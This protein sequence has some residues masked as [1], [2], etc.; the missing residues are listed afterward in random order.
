MSDYTPDTGR[1][2]DRDGEADFF[3]PGA[4][5]ENLTEEERNFAFDDNYLEDNPAPPP[6][7]PEGLFP[8][9]DSGAV[10]EGD[11]IV[12]PVPEEASPGG[13]DDVP[14]GDGSFSSGEADALFAERDPFAAHPSGAGAA[15]REEDPFA[16]WLSGGDTPPEQPPGDPFAARDPFA[17][18]ASDAL[19]GEETADRSG[20]VDALASAFRSRQRAEQ[21][22]K[23][24]RERQMNAL[25]DV[26]QRQAA[27]KTPGA[28]DTPG[29][30][31]AAGEGT[32]GGAAKAKAPVST[33]IE[34][35]PSSGGA[36]NRPVPAGGASPAIRKKRAAAR[37]RGKVRRVPEPVTIGRTL[38]GDQMLVYDSELD[39]LD[40]TDDEDLP[41]LRDHMPIRFKR[42]GRTGIAGGLMYAA[43]VIGI[44]VILAGFAWLCASDVL[45]L[46]KEPRAAIV[47]VDEYVPE[48]DD[49]TTVTI[50]DKEV[51]IKVDIDQVAD[52][53]QQ[54]GI[55]EYQWLFKL[56]SRFSH[57]ETRIDPGTYDVS[58][59]LDYRALVT[60]LH[61]GSG[62]QTITRVTF[63]E[64]YSMEQIFTLLE[65]K[66]ICHKNELY[67]AAANYDFDYDFL[68]SST[69]GDSGRLEGFLFPDTYDFYEGEDANIAI[70]RFLRNMD[71]KLSDEIRSAAARRGLSIREL[72]TIAS[73][74]EKE[75]GSDDERPLMASVIYNRL[76]VGMPLQLD[77]T[78]NYIKGTSTLALTTADTEIDDPYNTYL[79]TGLTPGPICNPGLASLQAAAEP[80]S[81]DYWYWY[82]VDGVSTFFTNYNEFKAYADAHPVQS[83]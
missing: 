50:D 17:S 55:I 22:A 20:Q 57:A 29:K 42:Y 58:T 69:L 72:V 32:G 79:Y 68:D 81:T 67:E 11:P 27:S 2:P 52:A 39:E 10:G 14:A 70:N 46:N 53:L 15:A 64:G 66:H 43:F 30:A 3:F 25:F 59:E 9:A 34:T 62:N 40:Y 45:A 71:S 24:Q 82:S 65:E 75:A 16:E 26:F 44:S 47:T 77:S 31:P 78:I 63:P 48:G 36:R 33:A 80:E 60:A 41:E 1:G 61:F 19:S 73:Y 37:R 35:A 83:D 7:I 21:Q 18:A 38:R 54:A 8:R 12:P 28:G 6:E 74:I 5:Q 76:N 49:P 4:G 23:S 51:P 56:Y 13:D